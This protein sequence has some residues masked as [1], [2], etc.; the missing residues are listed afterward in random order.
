MKTIIYSILIYLILI[1]AYKLFGDI[2]SMYWVNYY[3]LISSVFN[4]ILFFKLKEFTIVK[5]YRLVLK[6]IAGYWG[7]MAIF[8]IIC[9]FNITLYARFAESA[10]KLT[11]GAVTILIIFIILTFKAYK[12]DKSNA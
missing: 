4:V 12:Y 7:V 8:H 1:C 5:K 10:N 3:W 9:F 2:K 6:L 11:I